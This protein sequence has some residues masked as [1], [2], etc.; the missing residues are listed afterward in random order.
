VTAKETDSSP[1]EPAETTEEKEMAEEKEVEEKEEAE[2]L[3]RQRRRTVEEENG[4]E[5]EDGVEEA[6]PLA[7]AKSYAQA[8]AAD[9][10]SDANAPYR[11]SPL[12]LDSSDG[13]APA[14]VRGLQNLGSAC[15]LN[16]VLQCLAATPG[17]REC[18]LNAPPPPKEGE[19]T[20]ALRR[21]LTKLHDA[22]AAADVVS[23]KE[24]LASI[25]RRHARYARGKQED[26]HETWNLLLEVLRVEKAVGME[27]N[28]TT[29]IDETF[30]GQTRSSVACLSAHIYAYMIEVSLVRTLCM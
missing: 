22:G 8:A 13:L 30:G 14:P 29:L 24:L 6:G 10:R 25:S 27:D 16:C 20:A 17:V 28:A 11:L 3:I 26:A 12:P 1:A 7:Q 15:H 5:E 18:F 9:A 19:L 21:F 23:P 4:M 2:K